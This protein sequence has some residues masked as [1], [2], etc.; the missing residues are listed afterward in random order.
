MPNIDL[1]L[2]N[3]A[4]AVKSDKTQQTLNSTPDLQEM[5]S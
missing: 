1:L 5:Y 3:I 2:D 4:Q